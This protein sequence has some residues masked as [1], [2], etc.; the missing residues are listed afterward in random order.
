[1][2][3]SAIIDEIQET[4]FSLQ[5]KL[6]AMRKLESTPAI[7]VEFMMTRKEAAAFIGRSVRQLDRLCESYKIKK[8]IVDGSV[9]IRRSS[10]LR[11]KGI[12]PDD[13]ERKSDFETLINKYK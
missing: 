7:D 2:D 4:I 13:T 10:L 12:I 6:D 11:F 3:F 1:M 8:E 9:R 5:D